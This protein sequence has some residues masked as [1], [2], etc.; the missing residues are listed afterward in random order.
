MGRG[1][2]YIV[3]CAGVVA[4]SIHSGAT[5]ESGGTIDARG[6]SWSN[7]GGCRIYV[8]G[9]DWSGDTSMGAGMVVTGYGGVGVAALVA[10]AG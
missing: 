9:Y 4:A 5:Y 6:G 3:G 7:R 2:E 1:I 10:N 8:G